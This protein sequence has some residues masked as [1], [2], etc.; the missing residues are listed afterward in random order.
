MTAQD[1]LRVIIGVGIVLFV[2]GLAIRDKGGKG[3]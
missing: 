1:A 2:I 3:E